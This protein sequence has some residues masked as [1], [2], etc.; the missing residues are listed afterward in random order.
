MLG[1]DV[2]YN[3]S[4]IVS[5]RG[6]GNN[7]T[8]SKTSFRWHQDSGYISTQHIPYISCWCAV[9]EMTATNG[10]MFMLPIERNPLDDENHKIIW[11]EKPRPGVTVEFP[12]YE[13]RK[14]AN[15]SDLDGY[16]RSDPG[17]EILCPAGSILVFSSLT[18]HCSSA[19]RSNSLRSAVNMQFSPVKNENA[20]RYEAVPFV[21]NSQT[22]KEAKQWQQ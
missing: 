12:A 1:D 5:K 17:V 20:F 7:N 16:F 22:T 6:V 4:E 21:V 8:A 15:S 3:H 10:A 2:Y 11:S 9:T 14:D 13:H 19:N 18:L